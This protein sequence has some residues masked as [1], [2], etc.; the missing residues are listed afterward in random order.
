MIPP[1]KRVHGDNEFST[2]IDF[3]NA[4]MEDERVVADG[5][6]FALRSKSDGEPRLG[7]VFPGGPHDSWIIVLFFIG[8]QD[9][10]LPISTGHNRAVWRSPAGNGESP[11]PSA[12][13]LS[14]LPGTNPDQ[15]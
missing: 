3:A 12:R 5:L 6:Y 8:P 4:S 10:D 7:V 15:L 14:S 11:S 9:V 1:K 13:I 2:S